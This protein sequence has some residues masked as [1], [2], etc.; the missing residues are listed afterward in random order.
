LGGKQAEMLENYTSRDTCGK[1]TYSVTET[2]EF[3]KKDKSVSG[4]NIGMNC[5][6]VAG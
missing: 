1:S 3:D 6:E 2:K 5:G 4:Y